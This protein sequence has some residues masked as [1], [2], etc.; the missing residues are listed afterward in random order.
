[1]RFAN[2][3][4]GDNGSVCH[5]KNSPVVW[6]VLPVMKYQMI[7]RISSLEFYMRWSSSFVCVDVC[8]WIN[9]LTRSSA[10]SIRTMRSLSAN[11][12]ACFREFCSLVKCSFWQIESRSTEGGKYGE[13]VWRMRKQTIFHKQEKSYM[14]MREKFK[15]VHSLTQTSHILYKSLYTGCVQSEPWL[16][17][18]T[19]ESKVYHFRRSSYTIASLLSFSTLS[20]I[21]QDPW[22][23]CEL[24]AT[25]LPKSRY[26]IGLRP[27]ISKLLNKWSDPQGCRTIR[28]SRNPLETGDGLFSLC[29]LRIGP[30]FL[31]PHYS[32]VPQIPVSI[33]PHPLYS[34]RG[35]FW[36]RV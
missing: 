18:K 9:K 25:Q 17:K 33:Q 23:P 27:L 28:G 10:L 2:L 15:L 4:V 32:R 11:F 14:W 1:M 13:C 5:S 3:Y 16:R 35:S 31:G 8:Y 24:H 29:A 36:M 6:I 19:G 20:T 12:S 7:I 22:F 21:R 34:I 30:D 26:K